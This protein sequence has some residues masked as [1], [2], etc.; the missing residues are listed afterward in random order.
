MY[1][2]K[3]YLIGTLTDFKAKIIV[4]PAAQPKYCKART[5][6]YFLRDKVETE[7]N[8]LVTEGTLEP[9]EVAEWA[10]P[11]VAVLKP[12][13]TNV[14]ICGDF[15]QTINPVLTLDKY[16]IP[17]VVDLFSTLAGG[18]VFSK[19]DLSQAYQQ[20]PLAD[21]SKQYVVINTHKGLFRYTRLPFGVSSAP[22]IF[23][24]VMENMLQ[25]IQNVIVYLDDILLSS[26]TESDHLKLIDHVLDRLEKA[27]LRAR[28]GK[29]QFFVPSVTYLGHKID[30]EGLH[31]L[32]D[33]VKAIQDAPS[34]T[35]VQELKAYL[36]LLTYYSRFLPNMSTVLSLLYHN[37][38]M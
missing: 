24:R 3:A 36:G 35:N 4:D 33:K 32:P 14:S 22:G 34:P 11:I 25:G 9:I 19:I 31:P 12:D 26:A 6:P 38:C 18:K 27:G 16:P 23:Q 15:K 29:C 28:K 1:F 37:P 5:V 2:R 10:A 13:K 21:K 30:A 8:R 17:K 20:L 7:L